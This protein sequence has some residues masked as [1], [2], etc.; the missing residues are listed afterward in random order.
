LT[1]VET[2]AFRPMMP[3][4]CGISVF[5]GAHDSTLTTSDLEAWHQLTGGKFRMRVVPGPHLF[6]QTARDVLVDAIRSD[7]ATATA[8]RATA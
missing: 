7:L 8:R 5:G 3:L 6:L 2:Y 1:A 4:S